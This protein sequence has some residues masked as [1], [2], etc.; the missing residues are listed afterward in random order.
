MISS[1][2][3][4]QIPHLKPFDSQ[5]VAKN[6]EYKT[7]RISAELN[8][9]PK[10]SLSSTREPTPIIIVAQPAIV[11]QPGNSSF[12]TSMCPPPAAQSKALMEARFELLYDGLQVMKG[13]GRADIR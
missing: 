10:E 8:I 5:G 2:L 4:S 1:L 7:S 3:A 6:I 13:R 11:G 9:A 12:T